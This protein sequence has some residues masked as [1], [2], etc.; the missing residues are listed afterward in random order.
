[1]A[2][3][4]ELPRRLKGLPRSGRPIKL[5]APVPEAVVPAQG[6][7]FYN[8]TKITES[9]NV[10]VSRPRTGISLGQAQ[11]P[12]C[13]KET[14]MTA[15][16]TLEKRLSRNDSFM[17]NF[18]SKPEEEQQLYQRNSTAVEPSLETALSSIKY[19]QDSA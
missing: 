3:G 17:L 2:T 11:E 16:I 9:R 8:T 13:P 1:M 15:I 12:S 14:N 4:S 19:R 18:I 10:L 7:G 5:T 6:T